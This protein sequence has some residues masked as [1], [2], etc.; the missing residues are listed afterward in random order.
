MYNLN[1]IFTK[2]PFQI[3]NYYINACKYSNARH[4]I[5]CLVN[6]PS[7]VVHFIFP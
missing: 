4:K 3:F 6:A 1:C 2:I 7:Q 5:A